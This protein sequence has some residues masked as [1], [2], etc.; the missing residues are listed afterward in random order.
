MATQDHS[1]EPVPALPEELRG[2][3]YEQAT[4]EQV[5]RVREHVRARLAA[6]DARWT[7]EERER[8]HAAFLDRLDAA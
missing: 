1:T 3:T 6:A 7:P 8:R 5:A 4:P 2:L